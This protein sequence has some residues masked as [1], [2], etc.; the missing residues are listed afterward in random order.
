MVKIKY[1]VVTY[2]KEITNPSKN[3]G[4]IVIE[5]KNFITLFKKNHAQFEAKFK[6]YNSAKE[7]LVPLKYGLKK[8]PTVENYYQY[9]KD[10]EIALYK[11]SDLNSEE[12]KSA[13]TL[14]NK[15]FKELV[16]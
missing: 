14:L 11:L 10:T 16:K 13:K 12:A 3:I 2:R 1:G 5:N 9:L 4:I 6:Y 15:K 7:I 8:K